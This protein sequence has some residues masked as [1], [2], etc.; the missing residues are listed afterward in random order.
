MAVCDECWIAWAVIYATS[1][2]LIVI[3]LLVKRARPCRTSALDGPSSEEVPSAAPPTRVLMVEP[4]LDQESSL[5]S[6]STIPSLR[7]LKNSERRL[8]PGDTTEEVKRR[9]RSRSSS[10]GAGAQRPPHLADRSAQRGQR[11]RHG[12]AALGDQP[13]PKEQQRGLHSGRKG[14]DRAHGGPGRPDRLRG[15]GLHDGDRVVGCAGVIVQQRGVSFFAG[16][17]GAQKNLEYM[18]AASRT[19]GSSARGARGAGAARPDPPFSGHLVPPA[20]AAT[21]A[22]RARTCSAPAR[23]RAA[24][25][26]L[27]LRCGASRQRNGRSRPQSRLPPLCA[28]RAR[29]LMPCA[30][31]CAPPI[32]KSASAFMTFAPPTEPPSPCP[33]SR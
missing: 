14:S 26:L 24:A 9:H 32:C 17:Q 1:V 11:R 16:D 10:H 4:E 15:E 23:R 22:R 2:A 7:R 19:L 30:P 27:G 8:T 13:P 12:A 18:G 29:C 28:M 6:I 20:A 31:D 3:A 25:R 33:R 5:R 21:T